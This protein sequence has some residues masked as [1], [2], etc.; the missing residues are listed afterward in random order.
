MKKKLLPSLIR[1]T[2]VLVMGFLSVATLHAQNRSIN[3]TVVDAQGEP[4]I[5][6]SVMLVGNTTV[7]TVT[8]LDG[9]YTLSV[10]AGANISVS[11][12]GYST[13]LFQVGSQTTYNI[14][15]NEDNEFLEE[16]VV[17]GYGVQKKSDITGAIASVKAED[18][19]NR[20]T[21]NAISAL[22]GKAAGV[23]IMNY[24][25]APGSE[26]NIQIRGY[27][28]NSS[29]RPLIIVDGLKVSSLG[30]LDP[31]N[32]QSMEILKD[33]A[34]AA[35]YGIEAGNGV[36]LITTKSGS[37]QK[38]TSRVFYNFQNTTQQVAHLPELLNAQEYMAYQMLA[39][40]VSDAATFDYDGHTD[41]YWPGLMFEKGYMRR[42]TVGF[43][44][45]N[46]KGSLYISL[47]STTNDGI[48]AGDKDYNQRLNAQ[49][50]AEY[51]MKPWL[52]VGINNSF[53]KT[54][55]RSV[56]ESA[57]SGTSVF[58][59]ILTH[60]PITPWN[61]EDSE[62]PD[63][64]RV[65]EL[66]GYDLPKDENG[67]YYGASVFGGNNLLW[68]PAIMRDRT[69]AETDS[70]NVNGTAYLNLTP[71]KNLVFTSRFGYRTGYSMRHSYNYEIFVNATE[72]QSFS[73]SANASNNLYY[74]WENFANYTYNL[75]KNTFTA[76]AGMSFQK[77]TSDS[78]SGSADKLSN[79]APNYRYM[80]NAVNTSKMSVGGT[81]SESANMSYYGRLGWSYGNKYN[82]QA[83]FRA[84]A[85]DT[86]KLDKDHRWGYF[87][88]VSAGWTLSNEDFMAGFKSATKI[89]FIKLRASWGI[90]GNV[91]SLGSYQYASTLSTSVSSGY[92][93]GNGMV[94]G[95]SPSTTLPNPNIKWE[96]SH[97]VDLGLDIRG[98][99][100]KLTIGID[101][102]DK[103]T[104]NL[105]TTVTPPANTGASRVYMNAGKVNNHGLEFEGSWRETRGDFRYGISGNF[106][107]LHNM[108]VEGTGERVPGSTR[109][110]ADVTMTYFEEGY[111]LWY[112][113][114][115]YV[116]SIDQQTGDPV[117]KDFNNDGVITAEDRD[118]AGKGM[119]DLTYGVTLELG[120]KGFDLMV[121][122]SGVYGIDKFFSL[123]RGDTFSQNTLR[124]YYV[125]AWQ[126]PS[127]TGY[128][129]PRPNAY[130]TFYPSSNQRVYDAS[131]FKIKQIQLGY[132]V[133]RSWLKKIQMSQLRAYVSLD[134]WFT[135]TKYP[136]LD[137]ETSA[138]GQGSSMA[139]D[140]GSYPMS[141]KVVFGLNVAF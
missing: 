51:K 129:Y 75:K 113:R 50:N 57:S 42:H 80:S 110:N 47:G 60:D 67:K 69:D 118:Y 108:V 105:L 64:L 61:Y 35:I 25:G 140:W 22:Q 115:F 14:T 93:F 33:A 130:D 72:S 91:N 38:G 48:V 116:D 141:K 10:P 34:S 5:G 111:P 53:T 138:S 21:T 59:T 87:P 104:M 136:G 4:I 3:G 26:A 36:I 20:T 1:I 2:A 11:C 124:E 86:S 7:G 55:A 134:D 79:Y 15:L 12:I 31:E 120:W 46:D 85:Y 82:L 132:T 28:S 23:Q 45:G 58:G 122:G 63:R 9:K 103:N 24:S 112:L 102:Y 6:A 29:T 128:K 70:F 127:S 119:P 56:S 99:K 125:N 30:Y 131:F 8:D 32:I 114:T 100:D 137:P 101:W 123:N 126:S 40:E 98:F 78:L 88:S 71:I 92:D 95:A 17:V 94:L 76:M 54:A 96:T 84:D 74:Q 109:Y 89:S 121:F 16:T 139:M 107:T 81:P 83:N 106:A 37:T 19:E 62:V 39:G 13:E 68:H 133:P 66:N 44:G 49:I 73:I 52:T 97:Q 90:N 77:S 135:F 41:T 43:Q 27:S 65:L 18:L 117:Y